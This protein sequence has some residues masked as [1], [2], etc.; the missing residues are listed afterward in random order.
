[1][2][3]QK[4]FPWCTANLQLPRY[5]TVIRELALICTQFPCLENWFANFNT[6]SRIWDW[7]VDILSATKI[8]NNKQFIFS[9]RKVYW[10]SILAIFGLHRVFTKRKIWNKLTNLF[11]QYWRDISLGS[12][13]FSTIFFLLPLSHLFHHYFYTTIAERIYRSNI[14][15]LPPIKLYHPIK[16]S[17]Q[18]SVQLGD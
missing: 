14:P 17:Y 10:K 16:S 2:Q 13:Q 4:L 15:W 5:N 18:N 1:M 8:E 12:F 11:V 3:Q 9:K 6:F 7:I